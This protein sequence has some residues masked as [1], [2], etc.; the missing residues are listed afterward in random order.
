MK[1]IVIAV[2]AILF[3]GSVYLG[4]R[5]AAQ[6]NER[7]LSKDENGDLNNTSTQ[8]N[9]L[10][11]HVSTLTGESPF[12]VSVWGMFVNNIE[13][14]HLVFVPLYPSAREESVQ[15]LSSAFTF[16]NDLI[17]ADRLIR[18]LEREYDID[19]NGYILVDNFAVSSLHAWI[20][21]KSVRFP[22]TEMQSMQDY[23]KVLSKGQQFFSSLC[24][25][26]QEG[27][28]RPVLNKIQWSDLLPDHFATSLT[29]EEMTLTVDTLESADEIKSCEVLSSQ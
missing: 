6:M 24:G 3:L 20:D 27:G 22:Q 21:Q 7:I 16:R 4:F 11:I 1:K 8:N 23:E 9:Y 18:R 5:A 17:I 26:F 28:V 29:F 14:P 13:S 10:I 15:R 19:I 2:I 25:H 12:L